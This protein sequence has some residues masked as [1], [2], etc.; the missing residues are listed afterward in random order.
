VVIASGGVLE[1]AGGGG[2][3]SGVTLSCF[4]RVTIGRDTL[5]GPDVM[6]RDSDSHSTGTSERSPTAPI[7]IGDRVWI[8]A[9]AMVLKGVKIGD[10]SVVAAGSIVTKD[11]PPKTLVAGAPAKPIREVDWV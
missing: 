7:E 11:V 9:R 8:G 6:I 2:L 10:G 3:N 5:I 1:I 4:E